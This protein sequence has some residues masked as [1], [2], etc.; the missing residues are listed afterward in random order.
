MVEYNPVVLKDFADKIYRKADWIIIQW[1]IAGLFAGIILG[2]FVSN[3]MDDIE[4]EQDINESVTIITDNVC[5]LF[6]EIGCVFG[7]S[8]GL[9]KT[10]EMRANAQLILCHKEMEHRLHEIQNLLTQQPAN[11]PPN[12]AQQYMQAPYVQQPPYQPEIP[13]AQQ[14]Q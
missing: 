12:V 14:K 11:I 1:A 7:I 2:F 9:E 8:V 13:N 6:I 4:E 5:F 10:L 3:M